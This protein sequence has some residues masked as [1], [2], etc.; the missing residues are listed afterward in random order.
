MPQV[1]VARRQSGASEKQMHPRRASREQGKCTQQ[2]GV[3]FL[4]I[5][6]AEMTHDVG[7]GGQ[8]QLAPYVGAALRTGSPQRQIESVRDEDKPA[9]ISELTMDDARIGAARYDS[10]RYEPGQPRTPL[11]YQAC[12]RFIQVGAEI[13]V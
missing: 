11:R 3:I 7:A 6:T 9:G 13:S 4:R 5:R 10:G 1:F 8:S 2:V 12:R